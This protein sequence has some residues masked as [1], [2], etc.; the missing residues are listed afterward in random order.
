MQTYKELII[1]NSRGKDI[2]NHLHVIKIASIFSA[3]TTLTFKNYSLMNSYT[4]SASF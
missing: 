4:V 3:Q 1:N 2:G